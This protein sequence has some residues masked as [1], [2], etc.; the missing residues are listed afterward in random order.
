MLPKAKYCSKYWKNII[1]NNI[2]NNGSLTIKDHHIIWRT[3]I[4][5]V[6]KLN[7]RDLY[8]TLMSNIENKSTSQIH[9]EKMFENKPIK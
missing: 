9:F 1:Q 4:V 2:N 5:S 7:A 8:S 3:R 6:S